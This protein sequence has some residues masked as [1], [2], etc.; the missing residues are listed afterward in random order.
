MPF[1]E[2]SIAEAMARLSSESRAF[3]DKQR[4]KKGKFYYPPCI[5]GH[6]SLLEL[7][8]LK[9]GLKPAVSNKVPFTPEAWLALKKGINEMGFLC[10]HTRF[11]YLINTI[12]DLCEPIPLDDPRLGEVYAIAAKDFETI[13][14]AADAYANDTTEFGRLMGYPECCLAFGKSLCNNVG[15]KS[16]VEQDYVWSRIYFR[17]YRNSTNFSKWLNVYSGFALIHHIPCH[18]N[19]P[20]SKKYAQTLY[21]L[22]EKENAKLAKLYDFFMHLPVLFWN[23]ADSILFQGEFEK[24]VFHYWDCFPKISSDSFY[25]SAPD[26]SLAKRLSGYAELVKKG[27]SLKLSDKCIGVFKDNKKIGIIPKQFEFECILVKPD[28]DLSE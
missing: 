26:F 17:S 25:V 15:I 24:G 16:K 7:L 13:K 28:T 18:L 19:C 23:C 4:L 9:N 27:N 10:G 12:Q 20:E 11:K 6:F 8:A 2:K 5:K 1:A 14:R 22:L 3:S 21:G